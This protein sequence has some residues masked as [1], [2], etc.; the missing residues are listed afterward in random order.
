[1]S[2][3]RLSECVQ[4]AFDHIMVVVVVVVVVVVKQ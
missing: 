3:R 2:R 4:V 1:M